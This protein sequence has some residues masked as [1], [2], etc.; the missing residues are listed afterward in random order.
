MQDSTLPRDASVW[1]RH[2]HGDG[3]GYGWL[4]VLILVSISFQLAAPETDPAQIVTIG[5]QGVTLIAALHVSGVR[6][7]LIHDRGRDSRA[8]GAERDRRS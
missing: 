8:R 6:R 7:W 1:R 3:F 4:L 2:A 5:L